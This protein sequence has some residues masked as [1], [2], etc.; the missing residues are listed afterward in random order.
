MPPFLICQV[1]NVVPIT[2]NLWILYGISPCFH[3]YLHWCFSVGKTVKEDHRQLETNKQKTDQR[4]QIKSNKAKP[5]QKDL[6]RCVPHP[7]V[8][9]CLSKESRDTVSM[10]KKNSLRC[11]KERMTTG[12]SLTAALVMSTWDFY[13]LIGSFFS[14][15]N[16]QVSLIVASYFLKH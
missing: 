16:F 14:P 4:E 11:A 5:R 2:V 7:S 1:Y 10:A 12:K 3:V 9:Q 6:A 13:Y 15:R 8:G